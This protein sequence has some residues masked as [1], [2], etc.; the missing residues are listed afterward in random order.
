MANK[1][2]TIINKSHF[3]E[4]P[5]QIPIIVFILSRLENTA[6]TNQPEQQNFR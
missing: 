1:N 3:V 5:L 4:M 2:Y 6:A